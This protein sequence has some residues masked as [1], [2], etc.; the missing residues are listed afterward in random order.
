[1]SLRLV[2]LAMALVSLAAC[3][4]LTP[5]RQAALVPMASPPAVTGHTLQAGEL[6]LSGG[7]EAAGSDL[8]DLDPVSNEGDPGLWVT[9]NLTRGS[10]RIGLSD[11]LEIGVHGLYGSI[12]SATATSPGVMD[13]DGAEWMTGVGPT[14][15]LAHRV[16]ALGIVVRTEATRYSLPYA[17]FKLRGDAP[18]V[19]RGDGKEYYKR[20]DQGY[21]YPWRF[22]A[23]GEVTWRSR[24]VDLSGG[25]AA[26]ATFTNNGFSAR[27]MPTLE[28]GPTVLVPYGTAELRLDPVRIGARTWYVANS[29][30]Y[31]MPRYGVG[32]TA[33]LLFGLAQR[34]GDAPVGEGGGAGTPGRSTGHLADA[35]STHFPT[36]GSLNR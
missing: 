18:E 4:T 22:G 25:A 8:R 23:S 11:S 34:S 10:G 17:K 12:A 7:L 6:A 28:P 32:V 26:H 16:G 14:L 29:P 3:T 31:S 35:S 30:G 2:A 1:M 33:G 9:T 13:L 36:A 27:P 19:I 20:Y 5:Y 24:H 15:G 21:A